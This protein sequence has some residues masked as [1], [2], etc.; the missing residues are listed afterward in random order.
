MAL[1]KHQTTTDIHQNFSKNIQPRMKYRGAILD[2]V[3]SASEWRSSSMPVTHKVDITLCAWHTM[4][5]LRYNN[6]FTATEQKTFTLFTS[7]LH[8]KLRQQQKYSI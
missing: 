5:I 7:Y 6:T 2:R 8:P 4:L 1:A 3:D